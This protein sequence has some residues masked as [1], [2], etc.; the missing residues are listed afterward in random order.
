MVAIAAKWSGYI[1]A[2]GQGWGKR[3][4]SLI[5]YVADICCGAQRSGRKLSEER[6]NCAANLFTSPPNPI[7]LTQPVPCLD[8]F[9]LLLSPHPNVVS[10]GGSFGRLNLG[11]W[12]HHTLKGRCSTQVV[13]HVKRASGHC[14]NSHLA[15]TSSPSSE[16]S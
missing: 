1:R 7:R 4:P 3:R 6:A 9:A 13:H 10:N 12:L 15:K 11:C 2:S 14:P 16:K 8:L 5:A